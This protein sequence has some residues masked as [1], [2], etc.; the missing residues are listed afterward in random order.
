[1]AASE[2]QAPSSR[3]APWQDAYIALGSNL[4]APQAQV[5]RAVSALRELD[6]CRFLRLSS[7]YRSRPLADMAQPDYINAVACLQTRLSPESLLD[8]LQ[9]LERQMGRPALHPRWGP[10]IID[11]DLLALGAEVRATAALTLP[12]PGIV[13]RNFVLYPLAEIAPEL[14][15]PGLGKVSELCSRVS[16]NGLVRL[17]D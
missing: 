17:P 13:Q 3:E 4:E 5:R 9:A 15:L 16:Y 2:D 14:I 10:R 7:L 12:H 6:D 11:L 1:M 8:A